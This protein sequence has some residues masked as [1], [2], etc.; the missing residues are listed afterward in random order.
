MGGED[1]VHVD[2]KWFYVHKVKEKF[3]LLLGE[4]MPKRVTRHKSHIVKAM[5]MCA[6]ARPRWDPERG[7]WFDGKIGCWPVV[8][9]KVA[10]RTSK[11]RKKGTVEEESTTMTREVTRRMFLEKVIP[12]IKAKWPRSQMGELIRIQQ[13][14]AKPHCLEEDVDIQAAGQE[15]GWNIMLDNQPAQSPDLNVLDLGYFRSIQTLQQQ[16]ECSTQK[17]LIKLVKDSWEASPMQT[18]DDVFMTHQMV[19]MQVLENCGGNLFALPHLQKMALRRAEQLPI[20]LEVQTR[21]VHKANAWL[22]SV[23]G[24]ARCAVQLPV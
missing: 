17:Q 10:Q 20:M 7:E 1:T 21:L 13:D 9:E 8:R 19:M 12:A 6:A 11:N 5:F 22:T 14:N 24:P 4:K 16:T 3:I 15:G 18:L 2:E 23:L